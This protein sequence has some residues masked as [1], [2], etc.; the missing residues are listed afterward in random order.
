M[1]QTHT[2][3]RFYEDKQRRRG[4]ENLESGDA[5]WFSLTTVLQAGHA[6]TTEKLPFRCNGTA[7]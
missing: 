5:S 7:W 3:Q 2:T 4:A 1:R 6:E